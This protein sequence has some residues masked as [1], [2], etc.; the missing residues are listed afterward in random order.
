RKTIVT[1][2]DSMNATEPET[3]PAFFN[4][5]EPETLSANVNA[6]EPKTVAFIVV[7]LFSMNYEFDPLEDNVT[8][9]MNEQPS[10]NEQ[11]S[12]NEQPTFNCSEMDMDENLEPIET[13]VEDEQEYETMDEDGDD[14]GSDEDDSDYI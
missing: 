5:S 14:S 10:V 8:V 13:L 9:S 11:P 3:M 1:E 7:E 4:T 2:F 12:F 6:S